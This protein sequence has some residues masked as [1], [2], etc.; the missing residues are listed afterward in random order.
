MEFQ[1]FSGGDTPGPPILGDGWGR[2]GKKRKG[3]K[4]K[5]REGKGGEG[6][7]REGKDG[8]PRKI[9]APGLPPAKSG[10][11]CMPWLLNASCVSY[12]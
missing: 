9:W 11:A 2:G 5:G 10:P 4:G 3:R 7:G 1:N 6:K 8:V 12:S